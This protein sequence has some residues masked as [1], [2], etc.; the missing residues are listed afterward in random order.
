MLRKHFAVEEIY[1][2]EDN[3]DVFIEGIKVSLVYFP[4]K[5]IERVKEWRGIRMASDY[6][7]FLNKL[8]AVTRRIETKD[9]IDVAFPYKTYKWSIKKIELDFE[10]KFKGHRF[11]LALGSLANFED[12]PDLPKWAEEEV[13]KML[14]SWTHGRG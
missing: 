4:Y 13:L 11:A 10:E 1:Y 3:V 2:G 7:I 8:Y 9:V 6:D 5:N 12:Y 14:K